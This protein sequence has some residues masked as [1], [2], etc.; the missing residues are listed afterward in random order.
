[1]GGEHAITLTELVLLEAFLGLPV[2]L[3]SSILLAL[4]IRRRTGR[5]WLASVILPLVA[6]WLAVCGAV[7]V[8]ILW[9]EKVTDPM[10]FEL[11]WMPV[12]VSSLVLF[13]LFGLIQAKAH[14][15]GKR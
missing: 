7:P 15:K 11:L 3:G 6:S 12:L 14:G 1:M 8:H 4:F 5:G 9:P 10:L 2:L 13:P